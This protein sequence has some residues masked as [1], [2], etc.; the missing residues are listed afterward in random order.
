MD[1]FNRTRMLLGQV[2]MNKLQDS[3]VAV[4]GI[5]GVGGYVVEALVRSGIGSI[6]LID[7]D[8]VCETNLN[9]QI[10]ALRSTIGRLKVEVMKE[11]IMDINPECVVNIHQC[12]FLPENSHNFDFS[13]YD[14]IVDCV[15]TVSAKLELVM[16]AHE[17]GVPIISSMGAGNKLNPQ[18]FEVSDIYKTSV[19]PLAR[20]MRYE[21]KKRNIP[22]LKVVYSRENP[23]K[24]AES[25]EADCKAGSNAFVPS[26]AGLILASE[27]IKDLI[28]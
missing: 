13:C 20:V 10:I 23:I 28:N 8:V 27:V 11:R 4:F 24:P 14:Y 21:L 17:A 19:C 25:G 2:G 9:R 7:N 6:D 15:D 18:E 26:V 5:G 3:R 12:F 22:H 1:A 16:K